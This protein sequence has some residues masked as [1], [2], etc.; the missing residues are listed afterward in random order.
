VVGTEGNGGR[1]GEWMI[2]LRVID[3]GRLHQGRILEGVLFPD[4]IEHAV[5]EDAVAAAEGRLTVSKNIECKTKP[6]SEV[7]L[8]IRIDMRS[9]RRAGHARSNGLRL[10]ASCTGGKD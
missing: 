2:E 10:S 4:A 1:P 8:G 9:I 3:G 6:G 7:L 5:E